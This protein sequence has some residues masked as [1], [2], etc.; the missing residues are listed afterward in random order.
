MVSPVSRPADPGPASAA[1]DSRSPFLLPTVAGRIALTA[2][3]AVPGVTAGVSVGLFPGLA[4]AAAGYLCVLASVTDLQTMRIA[5]QPCVVVGTA[6]LVLGAVYWPGVAGI[7]AVMIALL[8]LV[9]PLDLVNRVRPAQIGFGDV[10][11]ICAFVLCTAWW[12]GGFALLRGI[13]I[14]CLIQGAA[15]LALRAHRPGAGGRA[16]PFAPAICVGTA[17]SIVVAII[18]GASACT[19]FAGLL[20]CG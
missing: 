14:A 12:A 13:V 1:A 11:L 15:R 8:A 20:S 16:L 9:L 18:T 3:A 17:V 6:G 7:A 5:R 4:C 19:D 2:G 10:R